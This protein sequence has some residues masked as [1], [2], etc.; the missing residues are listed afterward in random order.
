M[1]KLAYFIELTWLFVDAVSGYL[2]NHSIFLPG[3]Q[4][5]SAVVRLVVMALFLIIILRHLSLKQVPALLLL[6]LCNFFALVHT[7]ENGKELTVVIADIQFLLKLM[8][9][10]FL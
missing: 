4:T 8:M 7:I 6:M 10:V 9:P 1:L 3:N 5:V 2:Q